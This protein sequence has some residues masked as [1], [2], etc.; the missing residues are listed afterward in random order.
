[1]A[2][3]PDELAEV[4]TEIGSA[5]PPSD[6]D[7]DDI[8][9]RV[10]GLVGVIRAVWAT[11]LADFL[12]NPASFTVP[13]EYGQNVAAN[14]EGIQKRLRELSG[15]PDD[16]NDIPPG[17]LDLRPVTSFQLVRPDCGR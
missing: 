13:G 15:L 6:S 8:H 11:R 5:D 4:R 3:E 14:I 1:M 7:L 16:S 12:S 10:L 17:G 9:D 2:L